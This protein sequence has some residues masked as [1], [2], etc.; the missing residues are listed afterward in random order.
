MGRYLF[1]VH[2]YLIWTNIRDLLSTKGF[3]N[4]NLESIQNQIKVDI[5]FARIILKSNEIIG[6]ERLEFPFKRYSEVIG[7]TQY[8][9]NVVTQPHIAFMNNYLVLLKSVDSAKAADVRLV[10][11]KC[12]YTLCYQY[13]KLLLS[14][15]YNVVSKILSLTGSLNWIDGLRYV[16]LPTSH[17]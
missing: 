17:L 13:W 5:T 16:Y 8:L 15:H 14:M 10:R 6:C 2:Q 4:W 1:N 7:T 12:F 9:W 3:D 11:S